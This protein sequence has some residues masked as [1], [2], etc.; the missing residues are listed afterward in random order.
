[1]SDRASICSIN[2]P[3]ASSV[4]PITAVPSIS[5]ASSTV[6]DAFTG[7]LIATFCPVMHFGIHYIFS[8]E[9]SRIFTLLSS[10]TPFVYF[11]RPK[12]IY[13]P[14]VPLSKRRVCVFR[15]QLVSQR[16]DEFDR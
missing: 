10:S 11:R 5:R 3:I 14:A 13:N 12:F 16:I 4:R 6:M 15:Y 9:F 7:S 2:L 8:K 1:M